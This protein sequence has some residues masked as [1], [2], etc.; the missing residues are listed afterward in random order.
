M[1]SIGEI[2]IQNDPS[3]KNI[4]PFKMDPS[5][6]RVRRPPPRKTNVDESEKATGKEAELPPKR[7][8]LP[9]RPTVTRAPSANAS[10][11][12]VTRNTLITDLPSQF[13]GEWYA[14]PT[15]G[16]GSCLI[17]SVLQAVSD[18]YRASS[19]STK[20]DIASDIRIGM[21]FEINERVEIS[22]PFSEEIEQLDILDRDTLRQAGLKYSVDD[23]NQPIPPYAERAPEW[24]Q[25][26]GGIFLNMLWQNVDAVQSALTSRVAD[27]LSPLER[28]D[29]R[30]V[31]Y[32]GR[33]SLQR[34]TGAPSELLV[35]YSLYGLT[36]LMN[37]SAYIGDELIKLVADY[38]EVNIVMVD[39][40]S[41]PSRILHQ[42]ISWENKERDFVFVAYVPGHYQ[43]IARMVSTGEDGDAM[44]YCFP[45]DHEIIAPF[46]PSDYDLGR[47]DNPYQR[48]MDMVHPEFLPVTLYDT[49]DNFGDNIRQI[50]LP[51]PGMKFVNKRDKAYK[52]L[53]K[54]DDFNYINSLPHYGMFLHMRSKFA[55]SLPSY[56][57]LLRVKFM[58]EDA[59]AI[60]GFDGVTNYLWPSIIE[61]PVY[62]ENPKSKSI[63]V[64]ESD[65]EFPGE[66]ILSAI[67]FVYNLKQTDLLSQIEEVGSI[68]QIIL[69]TYNEMI[70]AIGEAE[71][72]E[73]EEEEG[74]VEE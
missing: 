45:F 42:T 20:I 34:R 46:I 33:G 16:D 15:I 1:I 8:V 25:S 72:G 63:P 50:I 29:P 5:T 65:G 55:S 69:N 41:T 6:Q 48:G 19:N 13:V 12:S 30:N 73:A 21:A 22:T 44:Q 66:N 61:A 53:M 3:S 54:I 11:L 56:Y 35:D 36:H 27:Y 7:P 10:K 70:A 32:G 26:E 17:H 52:E 57:N 62:R 38:F 47:G 68:G 74:E 37:S 60:D 43:T 2:V 58:E 51:T 71:E 31:V 18:K 64:Y 49:L 14:I 59:F 9:K 4:F 40:S 23:F 24:Y 39:C 67:V 28:N